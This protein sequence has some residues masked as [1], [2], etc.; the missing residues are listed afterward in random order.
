[1]LASALAA[2]GF[3]TAASIAAATSP[4]N[5]V[6]L[7][8]TQV[9][10]GY[11]LKAFPDGNR[12]AGQVSLDLCNYVFISERY[13][14]A[15]LQVSYVRRGGPYLSNEVVEYQSKAKA[16]EA[17]AELRYVEHHCPSVPVRSPVRGQ[18]PTSFRLTPLSDPRLL[19]TSVAVLVHAKATFNGKPRSM[20]GVEIYQVRGKV[21]S[22]IYSFP[23]GADAAQER[24]GLHA[25][26]QSAGNLR[27]AV[28][29]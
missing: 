26:E 23:P 18:P 28:G 1:M 3:A 6:V 7:K 15:R 25:A 29:A 17:L 16:S 13:R 14:V 22:A 9:G 24:L 19:R 11:R 4:V 20:N 8:P 12:V 2:V 27:R 21:L 5:E 10:P